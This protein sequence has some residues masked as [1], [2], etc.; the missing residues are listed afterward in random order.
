MYRNSTVGSLPLG[1]S[2]RLLAPCCSLVACVLLCC[3]L[4]LFSSLSLE[5]QDTDRRRHPGDHHRSRRRGVP[6][7]EVTATNT[8]TGVRPPST[9]DGTYAIQPL[10]PGPY[11]VEVVAKG[12][13][14]VL[15]ENITVDN[16]QPSA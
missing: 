3:G 7:A 4:V 13:E 14:R 11:I 1:L 6:K 9:G 10:Q 8:D 16:A 15:Q 5:A 12:F 2:R